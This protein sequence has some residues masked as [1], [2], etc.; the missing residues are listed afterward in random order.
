M[1]PTLIVPKLASTPGVLRAMTADCTVEQV[2]M[3]PKLGEWSIGLVV[4]HLVESD[5][6]T[7]LPRLKRMLAEERPVFDK[8]GGTCIYGDDLGGLLDVFETT[9]AKVVGIF[10]SLDA[11]GW[12]R[13][14]VSP[15][16]GLLS[17]ADMA[18]TIA[19]HDVE[20]LRQLADCRAV[21]LRVK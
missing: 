21:V 16:R 20:H 10:R 12:Q 5:L 3:P 14:G 9:R 13:Q 2:W 7:F 15:S 11:A 4:R 6:D 17:I 18:R 1:D 19:D 8:Q